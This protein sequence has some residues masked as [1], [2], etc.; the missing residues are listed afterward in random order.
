[1]RSV[2]PLAIVGLAAITVPAAAQDWQTVTT[3]RQ[4]H[5]EEEFTASVKFLSGTLRVFPADNRTLY[6][7]R[8]RY[9]AEQFQP[10]NRFNT[11]SSSLAVGLD[12]NDY[13]GDLDLDEHSPQFLDL[14][15]PLAIPTDL[16]LEF[17]VVRADIELGG[18]AISKVFVRTGASETSM[19]F[20]TPNNTDCSRIDV[21]A[22]GARID[23]EGLGNS[24]CQRVEVIGGAGDIT[25]DFTGRWLEGAHMQVAAKIG[26][27]QLTLVIP[28]DLGVR[29]DL[30]R[31]L[32][33]FDKA[34]FI[35]RGSDRSR[36]YSPNFGDASAQVEISIDAAIGDVD[37]V[38]VEQ[39]PRQ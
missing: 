26:L 31:F 6:K 28:R 25:L 30:N 3:S 10:I 14:E 35:Q 16:R 1:M 4:L 23:L 27:G 20:S 24:R 7:A 32:V 38:W 12:A 22:V 13:K 33:S 8:M 21:K 5:G 19:R 15:L 2:F 17:G 39:E 34:G 9:D 18:I 37:V 29:V 36:W 11:G